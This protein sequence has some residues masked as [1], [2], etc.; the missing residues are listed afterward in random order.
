MQY[1]FWDGPFCKYNFPEIYAEKTFDVYSQSF[2]GPSEDFK[3]L[4]F[5]FI[6]ANHKLSVMP[7]A[8]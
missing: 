8:Y 3:W 4:N 7:I 6:I 2:K 5:I 1:F